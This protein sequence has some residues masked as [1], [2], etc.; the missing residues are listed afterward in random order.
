[1]G[2]VNVLEERRFCSSGLMENTDGIESILGS[3]LLS[4]IFFY[5]Y[6]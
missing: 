1:M 5:F 6:I 4:S 2:L 3:R